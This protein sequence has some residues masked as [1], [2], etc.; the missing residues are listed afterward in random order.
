MKPKVTV[1]QMACRPGYIDSTVASLKAQTL[2]PSEWEFILVDD[3]YDELRKDL[4]KAF[5]GDRLNFLHIP[6]KKI[7]P[8]LSAT[9]TAL[10]T[11]I[12]CAQGE[13][14]YFMADYM[15]IHPRCLERHWEIYSKYGDVLI[16]GPLID[17]ITL[18]GKSV[19]LG[20][21]PVIIKVKVGDEVIT[22]PEHTPPIEWEI[23][24]RF[25]EPLEENLISIWRKPFIKPTWPHDLPPDWRLGACC[26]IPLEKNLYENLSGAQWWWAG[27]NDSAPRKRLLEVGGMDER[28]DGQHGGIETDMAKRMNLRYLIDREAPAYMLPH[29][30]RKKEL[31]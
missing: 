4:V 1:L 30:T 6:P 27:R 7:S 17:R 12:E 15:Y 10:N 19:W 22:F 21:T 9:A 23:K 24:E 16:S 20:A 26:S 2:P 3:L 11:G 29:P 25:E 14:I 18:A 13:L 31:K 28:L 8:F 5:I